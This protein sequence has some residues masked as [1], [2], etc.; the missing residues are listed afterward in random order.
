MGAKSIRYLLYLAIGMGI[1]YFLEDQEN[2]LK[3]I[4]RIA[5]VV[6]VVLI[7]FILIVRYVKSR[8]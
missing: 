2:A 8:Q 3:E 4:H 5:P 6:L 7:L 1:Y